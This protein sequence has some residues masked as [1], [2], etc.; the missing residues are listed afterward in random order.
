M[1]ATKLTTP[2]GGWDN[3][4]WSVVERYLNSVIRNK[5]CDYRL[6]RGEKRRV[7]AK[8]KNGID[9]CRWD[10]CWGNLMPHLAAVIEN[11]SNRKGDPALEALGIYISAIVEEVAGSADR[12]AATRSPW[13]AR[14]VDLEAIEARDSSPLEA[15]I[16]AEEE[17]STKERL[18]TAIGRLPGKEGAVL[19]LIVQ[20]RKLHE[21]A[22]NS[23]EWLGCGRAT[24][25]NRYNKAVEKLT[26]V[27][28]CK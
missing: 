25:Y 10:V 1:S 16:E 7:F 11:P 14:S 19:R 5:G 26:K 20:G 23:K 9:A 15:V 27:L 18:E 8:V 3:G 6:T 4:S 2:G 28:R 22:E 13:D 21:I 12:A 17:E 24:V